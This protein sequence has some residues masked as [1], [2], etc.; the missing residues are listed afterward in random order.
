MEQFIIAYVT[1]NAEAAK[2]AAAAQKRLGAEDPNYRSLREYEKNQSYNK[3]PQKVPL[4]W[5]TLQI[6]NLFSVWG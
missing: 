3:D 2:G 1:Q 4:I 5:E 6:P